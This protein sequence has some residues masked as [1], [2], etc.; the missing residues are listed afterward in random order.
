MGPAL[1]RLP[2]LQA[3]VE[4]QGHLVLG[5]CVLGPSVLG[6]PVLELL[7]ELQGSCVGQG[8]LIGP[9]TVLQALAAHAAAA[10]PAVGRF[11]AT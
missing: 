5:C 11:G 6:C 10:A 4:A 7:W 9:Q 1:R 3:G 8:P 2:G